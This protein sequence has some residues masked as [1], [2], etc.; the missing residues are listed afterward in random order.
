VRFR[1]AGDRGD[2]RGKMGPIGRN[3]FSKGIKY[4]AE[5]SEKLRF[6]AGN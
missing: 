1:F 6:E 2:K 5:L 3:G 4:R